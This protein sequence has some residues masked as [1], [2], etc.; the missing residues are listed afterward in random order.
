MLYATHSSQAVYKTVNTYVLLY[1]N[2]ISY[3]KTSYSNLLA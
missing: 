1:V 2:T 3:E